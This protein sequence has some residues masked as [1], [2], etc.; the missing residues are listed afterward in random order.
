MLAAS[1]VRALGRVVAVVYLVALCAGGAVAQ[2]MPPMQLAALAPAE[3]A[4]QPARTP[5][6][7]GPFGNA[8][9]S[10]EPFGKE[11]FAKEPFD[12]SAAHSG[13]MFAKWRSL[14]PAIQ[15]EARILE[16]CRADAQLCT[17][18][19]ARFLSVIETA[20]SRT[21]R[22]RIG[23]INRA[24][25]LAIRPESDLVRFHVPDVWATPLM[26][27]AY[28]AGDCEDY[29]IAKYVALREAG[30][31]PEDLRIVITRN[32]ALG[33]DHAVTAARVDG[34][35]LILDNRHMLLLTDS[36]VTTMTPLVTLDHDDGRQ[37]VTVAEAG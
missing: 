25:N 15:I 37:T 19:A 21:G 11:P 17:P 8:H 1:K 26:T 6:V 30:V 27:F 3:Q 24:I 14:Q 16:F 36:Q 29:A 28:G 5:P 35:W 18:A 22:A 9:F 12:M 2:S 23:E 32:A 31:S 34:E 13:T 33:Q 20:R 7:N 4:L 10:K